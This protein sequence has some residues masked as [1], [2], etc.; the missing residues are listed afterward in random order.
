[1]FTTC[2]TDEKVEF[3]KK[4]GKGDERLHPINYRTQS[5]LQLPLLG[6]LEHRTDDRFRGGDK[7]GRRGC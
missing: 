3:L 2:G 6:N 7:E 5:E 4:L 1:M